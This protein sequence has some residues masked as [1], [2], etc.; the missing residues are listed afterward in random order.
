[1]WETWSGW[2]LNRCYSLYRA[3]PG[4]KKRIMYD[5]IMFALREGAIS[6]A[7]CDTHSMSRGYKL[8]FTK[9]RKDFK[10][11]FGVLWEPQNERKMDKVRDS[12]RAAYHSEV[13]RNELFTAHNC[14][15]KALEEC[16]E[17]ERWGRGL[18]KAY[19]KQFCYMTLRWQNYRDG[20]L[21][22]AMGHVGVL[23]GVRA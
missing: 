22:V 14:L 8:T 4:E 23:L 1:M 6:Q 12:Y 7:L 15:K 10:Y 13:K 2:L 9:R 19:V 3:L 18:N 17:T 11:W 5:L 21:V 20:G 16:W